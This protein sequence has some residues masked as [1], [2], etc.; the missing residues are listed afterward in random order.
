VTWDARH[1]CS[2][3]ASEPSPSYSRAWCL[4]GVEAGRRGDARNDPMSDDALKPSSEPEGFDLELAVSS[5]AADSTD[6]PTLLRLLSDQLGSALGDRLVVERSGGLRRR[7]GPIKALQVALGDDVLRADVEGTTVR[8]TIGHSSAGIRIR[9]EQVDM[10]TWLTRLLGALKSEANRS[11][12][13][14]LA[15]ENLMLKGGQ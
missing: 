4:E 6:V 2:A 14:R 3:W 13:T 5:L 7:S 1:R 9:S 8:C 12:A 15:L 10:A 11:Q